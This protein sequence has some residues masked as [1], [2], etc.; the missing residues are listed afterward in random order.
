[1]YEIPSATCPTKFAPGNGLIEWVK[2]QTGGNYIWRPPPGA[3]IGNKVSK[4]SCHGA[5]WR[6]CAAS[7]MRQLTHSGS[8]MEGLVRCMHMALWRIETPLQMHAC[9][10]WVKKPGDLV[11]PCSTILPIK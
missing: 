5:Q 9:L 10:N 11:L 6:F 1:V 4:A 2:P 7:L 3:K 8:R